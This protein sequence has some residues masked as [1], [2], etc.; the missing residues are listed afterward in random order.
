MGCETNTGTMSSFKSR[1]MNVR[2]IEK[3]FVMLL[4]SDGNGEDQC[5]IVDERYK[6][7]CISIS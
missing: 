7:Q 4:E 5:E 2:K 3:S 1:A 6:Q